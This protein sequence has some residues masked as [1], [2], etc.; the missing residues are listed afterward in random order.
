MTKKEFICQ[1][2]L[3]MAKHPDSDMIYSVQVAID[4]WKAIEKEC[5]GV[6]S[7]R[8][9]A[10]ENLNAAEKEIKSAYQ[11]KFQAL[12]DLCRYDNKEGDE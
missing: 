3:E 8:K 1:Y 10:E 5:G 4:T 12:R 6:A 2:I 11:K 7:T 9:Q